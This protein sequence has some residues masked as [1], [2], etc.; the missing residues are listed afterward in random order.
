M[1]TA[2]KLKS[3]NWR[4][5]VY[6]NVLKKQISLTA[7]TRWEAEALADNYQRG[8]DRN[9]M[10]VGEAID[11]Y[12]EQ[13]SNILS[14]TTLSAYRKM[15]KNI[16]APLCNFRLMD[17]SQEDVQRWINQTSVDHAPKYV[18]NSYGFLHAVTRMYRPTFLPQ[19]TLPKKQRTYKEF[20]TVEQLFAVIRG[21]SVELPCLLAMWMGMR[22]SEIRGARRSHIRDGVLTID[23]TVVT[24]DG[25]RVERD[26]TKTAASVRQLRLPPYILNLIDALPPDQ[27]FL[28]TRTGQSIYM[29]FRYLLEKNGLPLISFHDLRHVNA[30]IM[31]ALGIPDKY[32]MERGGWSSN[33]VLK[34]VY[35]HTFSAERKLV[36][37]RI[38]SFF[39][40]LL[41]A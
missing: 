27:D 7:P 4:I 40:D 33:G 14:P 38:D 1:A 5:R 31:L 13:K 6:D 10:T 23:S 3:G 2:H 29:S 30:S 19:I 12:L 18:K 39:N 26:R 8:R 16:L 21:T 37:E 32:A 17:L 9:R 22:M 34:S 24:V 35:Q 28:T 41:R 25:E 20:P 36:D 15:K 11:A